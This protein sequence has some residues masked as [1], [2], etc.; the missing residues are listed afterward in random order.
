M[1]K[2][3]HLLGAEGKKGPVDPVN[4][5]AE[6]LMRNNPTHKPGVLSTPR[7]FVAPAAR[8]QEECLEILRTW[9]PGRADF[10]RPGLAY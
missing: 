9:W 10:S 7:M 5:L 4:F 3:P 2:R 1:L 8:R 6:F